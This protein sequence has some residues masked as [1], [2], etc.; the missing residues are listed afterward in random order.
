MHVVAKYS[1]ETTSRQSKADYTTCTSRLDTDLSTRVDAEE[2]V[3]QPVSCKA[4]LKGAALD[5]LLK[6]W[7][8]L[9]RHQQV[10][11]CIGHKLYPDLGT[12]PEKTVYLVATDM[13]MSMVYTISFC[14]GDKP[15]L[16]LCSPCLQAPLY[17]GHWQPE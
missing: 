17:T 10:F 7:V 9:T 13:H 4:Q 8:H 12:E 14:G 3:A 16:G 6:V 11:T 1:H 5:Q 15:C 2:V